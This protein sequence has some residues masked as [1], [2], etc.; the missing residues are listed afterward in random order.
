M[1]TSLEGVDQW[2]LP[3]VNILMKESI[4]SPELLLSVAQCW[5]SIY[6]I[7]YVINHTPDQII[8]NQSMTFFFDSVNDVL[9]KAGVK[10]EMNTTAPF[11][12]LIRL[13][14]RL[15]GPS[16]FLTQVEVH[17]SLDWMIP[18]D[19]LKQVQNHHIYQSE[20]L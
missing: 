6:R 2:P 1:L 16:W 9:L 3:D 15:H 18:N 17:Q 8:D 4:N 14:V 19:D 13:M 5:S 12:F 7:I 11:R 10:D 20:L